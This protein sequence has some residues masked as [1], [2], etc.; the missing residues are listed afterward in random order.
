[1]RKIRKPI[2]KKSNY[3]KRC[4]GLPGDSLS[5]KDGFV[6]IDQKRNELPGR[7]KLQF[8]YYVQTT[9]DL[10]PRYMYERYGVTGSFGK[11]KDDIYFFSAMTAEAA[12][13]LEDNPN[14]VKIQR[15]TQAKGSTNMGEVFPDNS[16]DYPWNQDQFGPIYIPEEGKT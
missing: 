15:N 7:A 11:V 5:I 13:Q 8:S 1:H 6:Y 12:K 10:T 14:V 4:V 9:G 16:K 3:V 2:D